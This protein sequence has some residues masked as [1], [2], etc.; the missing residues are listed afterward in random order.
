M[1]LGS[2]K[3]LVGTFLQTKEYTCRANYMIVIA[4]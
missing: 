4:T 3:G 2:T 1:S